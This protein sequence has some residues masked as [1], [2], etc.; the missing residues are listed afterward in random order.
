MTLYCAAVRRDSASLLKF[1]FPCNIR[2]FSC[3]MSLISRLK[4]PHTCFSSYFCFLV[5][6]LL[7]VL[8]SLGLLLV[9]VISLL[10]RFSIESSSRCIDTSTLSSMLS[11]PLP[12]SFLDTSSLGCNASC[13]VISFYL[14]W[15]ICLCSS[16]VHFKNRPEY[17][18]RETAEIFIPIIRFLICNFVTSSF[19][20]LLMYSLLLAFFYL[21]L[22]DGVNF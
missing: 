1:P 13:M 6:S 9:A 14:R 7:F 16:L 2:I 12:P 20:V 8:W 19:L 3:D 5:I 22:F 18:T 21:Q 11:S 17:L 15:S 4:R 10:P